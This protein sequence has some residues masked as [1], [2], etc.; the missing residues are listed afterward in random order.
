MKINLPSWARVTQADIEG[1]DLG[2]KYKP[3]RKAEIE[4]GIFARGPLIAIPTD[5]TVDETRK[6]LPVACHNL[7][8]E[9]LGK[10]WYLSFNTNAVHHRRIEINRLMYMAP[11][12]RLRVVTVNHGAID[13]RALK[14]GD[15]SIYI[16]GIDQSVDD[17]D[18]FVQNIWDGEWF[19]GR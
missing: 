16:D 13:H 19:D 7:H 11:K 17:L 10:K 2:V 6:V 8:L 1:I 4:A 3:F 14:L 15:K 9:Q 18:Q 12:N 5:S